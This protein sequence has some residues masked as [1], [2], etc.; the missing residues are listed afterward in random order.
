[1][2][3]FSPDGTR[4]TVGARRIVNEAGVDCVRAALT[5]RAAG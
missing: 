5:G 2:P 1:M 3:K 4:V